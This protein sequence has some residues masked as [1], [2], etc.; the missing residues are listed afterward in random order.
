VIIWEYCAIYGVKWNSDGW[1]VSDDKRVVQFFT[2]DGARADLEDWKDPNV[3][4][5]KIASL[6]AQGWEMVGV[7]NLG[8]DRHAIYFKRLV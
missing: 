1:V 8:G 7:V 6:G 3:I 5:K 4:A 2:P